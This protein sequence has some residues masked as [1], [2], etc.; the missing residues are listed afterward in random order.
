MDAG[1]LARN[2]QSVLPKSISISTNTIPNIYSKASQ[3]KIR[4]GVLIE[5]LCDD[6]DIKEGSKVKLMI[7]KGEKEIEHVSPMTNWTGSSFEVE[8]WEEYDAE[9]KVFVYGVE[10]GDFMN[11][12]KEQIGI[13]AAGAVKELAQI[14]EEQRAQLG[15]QRAQLGEQRA[16]LVEQRAQLGEQRAQLGE[17]RERIDKLERAI[18]LLLR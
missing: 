18:Q 5:V 2:V 8:E 16:Q 11:V 3:V 17:Q 10:V 9:D 14:V 4:S 7:T 6:K 12:D 13:L 1:V 15:E